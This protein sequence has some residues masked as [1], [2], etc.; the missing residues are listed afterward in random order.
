MTDPQSAAGLYETA[1]QDIATEL[2]KPHG[3]SRVERCFLLKDGYF[4]HNR[5]ARAAFDEVAAWMRKAGI[6]VSTARLRAYELSWRDFAILGDVAVWRFED[7]SR[8]E[9]RSLVVDSS[10]VERRRANATWQTLRPKP[11][12][13]DGPS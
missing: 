5:D 9:D 1:I 6:T 3:R 12:A 8:I 2:A 13:S 10:D 4:A 7:L 11:Y